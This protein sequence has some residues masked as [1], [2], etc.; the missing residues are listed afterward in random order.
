M[1]WLF[2]VLGS[3]VGAVVI[4]AGVVVTTFVWLRF[5]AGSTEGRRLGWFGSLFVEVDQR[6]DGSAGLGVGF[7]RG[8]AVLERVRPAGDR[9]GPRSPDG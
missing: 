9:Q 1:K 3:A 7:C 2:R 4:L 5:S 8:P 6:V